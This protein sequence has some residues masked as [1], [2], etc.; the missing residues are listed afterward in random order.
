VPFA[1]PARAGQQ[2]QHGHVGD[3]V[4]EH[5]RRVGDHDVLRGGMG[6]IDAVIA[7][8]E[9]GDDLQVR[10]CVDQGGIGLAHGGDPGDA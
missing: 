2:H 7:D 8:A 3:I 5:V 1:E 6:S 10:Q 9:A 4:V